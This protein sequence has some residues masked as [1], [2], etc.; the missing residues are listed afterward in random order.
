MELISGRSKAISKGRQVRSQ[1]SISMYISIP[2]FMGLLS[3][4]RCSKEK[5]E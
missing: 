3:P 2:Q 4:K 5:V 1:F